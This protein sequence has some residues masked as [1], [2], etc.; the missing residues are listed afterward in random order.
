M[1]LLNGKETALQLQNQL[2]EQVKV[3]LQNNAVRPPHL[4]AIMVG[5]NPASQAYVRNKIRAC[6]YV[7]FRSSLEQLPETTTEAELLALIETWNQ[8]ADL[9][10]F[11][12]Q[13]PLPAHISEQKVILALN[14]QKDVDG[15]HPYNLGDLITGYGEG[16]ISATPLG[17]L[18]L[19]KAYNLPTTGKNCVVVGRSNIV[20]TPISL[21]LSRNQA[22]ANCTVT[23]CHSRTQNLAAH[24]READILVV[25]LGKP[26]FIT[27][28]MVKPGA[29]VIDVGIHSVPDPSHKSGQKLVGDVD[30]EQVAP[31]CS[32]IS[33]VPG[34]VGAMTVTAL[35]LNTWK[36][37][38]KNI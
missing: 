23:L 38:T 15:F 18:E 7:G 35:L 1:Q 25:A 28:D 36:S 2:R 12:V 17:I 8:R 13:L 29:V 37:Y 6:E 10:G 26:L 16:F 14:P 32:L 9:D 22:F 19:I 20:G 33:P 11:I 5:E 27:A 21:L 4:G 34:G 24:T 3:A 30:F 31:K